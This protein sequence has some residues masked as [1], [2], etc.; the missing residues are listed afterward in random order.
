MIHCD[1]AL[2]VIER[3]KELYSAYG[4][5]RSDVVYDPSIHS[6][7]R[8]QNLYTDA[9]GVTKQ[10][11]CTVWE[12]EVYP[13][14]NYM[15]FVFL[16]R[17]IDTETDFLG[18]IHY[19]EFDAAYKKILNETKDSIRAVQTSPRVHCHIVLRSDSSRTSSALSKFYHVEARMFNYPQYDKGLKLDGCLRYLIHGNSSL[20]KIP[21]DVIDCFGSVDLYQ[22]LSSW[23]DGHHLDREDIMV[24]FMEFLRHDPLVGFRQTFNWF[25]KN[26]YLRFYNNP[27]F[28]K[29]L[30]DARR[31]FQSEYFDSLYHT[32]AEND[33][34]DSLSEPVV[35]ACNNILL[36]STL[37]IDQKL[38][39]INDIKS[40]FIKEL[41]K[42]GLAK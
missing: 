37:T 41:K 33:L 39:L 31:S 11:S 5:Y 24:Q 34:L 3:Y 22:R 29:W 12:L 40:D 21:Y 27:Q 42:K 2:R 8:K 38:Q 7:P 14:L 6:E 26:G 30:N 36:S 17:L 1:H 35:G 15:H 25:Q 32:K 16:Q 10:R 18:I 13:S 20:D 4:M 28:Y 19:K 9:N 23:V